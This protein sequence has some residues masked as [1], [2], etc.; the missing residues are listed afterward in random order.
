M[1]GGFAAGECAAAIC[2]TVA[3]MQKDV[4]PHTSMAGFAEVLVELEKLQDKKTSKQM[5]FWILLGSLAGFF[6]LGAANWDWKFTLW[7]IPV[8]LFHEA[9]HFLEKLGQRNG[10]GRSED[11]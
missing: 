7:L 3:V 5:M 4:S 1:I 6:A 2:P 11:R 10:V 9:G 8:L